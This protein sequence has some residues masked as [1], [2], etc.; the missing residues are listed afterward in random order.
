M[1]LTSN[2]LRKKPAMRPALVIV[3]IALSCRFGNA[4]SRRRFGIAGAAQPSRV[5]GSL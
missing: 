2:I 3:A 5:V 4:L 1:R